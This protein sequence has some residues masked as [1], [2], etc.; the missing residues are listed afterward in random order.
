MK[1]IETLK[2]SNQELSYSLH[3][4]EMSKIRNVPKPKYLPQNAKCINTEIRDGVNTYKIEYSFNSLFYTMILSET[5]SVITVY[6]RETKNT[7]SFEE[8]TFFLWLI[9]LNKKQAKIYQ[10]QKEFEI[11]SVAKI[12]TKQRLSYK[13]TLLLNDVFWAESQ[14]QIFIERFVLQ[15]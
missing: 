14:K 15:K 11:K 10:K 8:E 13:E 4:L 5:G 9:R 2:L 12:L 1:F 7:L 6:P 3:A